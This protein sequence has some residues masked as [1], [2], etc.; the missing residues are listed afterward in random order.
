MIFP[1]IR[2]TLRTSLRYLLADFREQ[3][4][5]PQETQ[6]RL[7]GKLLSN[8]CET[9]YGR[10]LAVKASD[11]YD[12]FAARVPVVTYDDLS[13]WIER[14]KREEGRALTSEPVLFYEKTSGSSGP[15]KY[16]PYTAGL[17][18]SFNRMFFVWL[19]DLLENGP[20]F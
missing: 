15:A 4:R 14:Q 2:Q 1:I 8:L 6:Q 7:L 11:A 18:A 3:L 10:S 20:R 17:K 13:P 19:G 16:I 5:R 12:D 9:E